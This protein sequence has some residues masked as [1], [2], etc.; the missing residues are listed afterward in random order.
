[1]IDS[2]EALDDAA[3]D[4]NTKHKYYNQTPSFKNLPPLITFN[5]LNDTRYINLDIDDED[6]CSTS[7]S[8]KCR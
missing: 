4:N 1:M 3:R 5:R 2:D 7:E 8:F 6:Y